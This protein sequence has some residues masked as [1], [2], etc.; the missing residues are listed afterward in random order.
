MAT[1]RVKEEV[2]RAR[3]DKEL[4]D[5]L[6]K[7]CE[8]KKMSMSELVVY[9]VENEVNKYEFKMRNKKDIDKRIKN[10]EKKISELKSKFND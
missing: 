9:M 2:I 1:K 7:M 4:K 3:V 5:K 10:T 8:S 6:K